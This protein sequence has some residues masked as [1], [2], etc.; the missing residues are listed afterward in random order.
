MAKTIKPGNDDDRRQ[1]DLQEAGE[2]DAHPGVVAVFGAEDAL[3]HE[4][5]EHVVP[6]ADGED[7][8]DQAGPGMGGMAGRLDHGEAVVGVGLGQIGHVAFDGL[9]PGPFGG[10]IALDHGRD[11]VDQRAVL[12]GQ[13]V[14]A[15]QGDGDPADDHDDDGEQVGPGHRRQSAVDGPE[16]GHDPEHDDR[17]PELELLGVVGGQGSS[18]REGGRSTW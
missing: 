15:E 8:E 1:Q 12:A 5:V 17:D 6:D 16:S 14:E 4:L 10:S 18:R 13:G 3:D 2:D 11:A 9:S 7:A